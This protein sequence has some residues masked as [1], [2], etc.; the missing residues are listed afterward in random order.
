VQ[1]KDSNQVSISSVN[2]FSLVSVETRQ[3][4]FLLCVA[5]GQRKNCKQIFSDAYCSGNGR[6]F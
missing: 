2:D 6:L 1:A 5:E 3:R 4:G